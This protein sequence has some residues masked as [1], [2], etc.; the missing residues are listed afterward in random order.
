MSSSK[1]P[2]IYIGGLSRRTRTDDLEKAFGKYGKIRDISIKGKYAFVVSHL[3]RSHLMQEFEDYH[4]ARE[5]VDRMDGFKLDGEKLS[6]EPTSKLLL[7]DTV[8][9]G[10]R[11]TRSLAER[12]V[13][14]MWQIWS[15]VSDSLNLDDM[16]LLPLPD[17]VYLILRHAQRD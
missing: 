6:V 5:A 1:N 10:E 2:Q 11:Q 8:C 17:L 14:D 7:S 13:L 9:R 4:H 16:V 15:L 12:Q 3:A